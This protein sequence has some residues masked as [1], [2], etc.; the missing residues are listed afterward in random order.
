MLANE[1]R[2]LERHEGEGLFVPSDAMIHF[3]EG[4]TGTTHCEELSLSAPNGVYFYRDTKSRVCPLI[5]RF[6][7]QGGG[8]A[9]PFALRLYHNLTWQNPDFWPGFSVADAQGGPIQRQIDW[10]IYKWIVQNNSLQAIHLEDALT[11]PESLS[12]SLPDWLP[13]NAWSG[14]LPLDSLS[15]SLPCGRSRSAPPHLA[16]STTN[17][18]W[19]FIDEFSQLFDE[20]RSRIDERVVGTEATGVA[21]PFLEDSWYE[22]F[23]RYASELKHLDDVFRELD[24]ALQVTNSPGMT[25]IDQGTLDTYDEE[26]TQLKAELATQSSGFLLA[27]QFL[28]IQHEINHSLKILGEDTIPTTFTDRVQSDALQLAEDITDFRTSY[29]EAFVRFISR[30]E[31]KTI[32]DDFV[33]LLQGRTLD[34][35][36]CVLINNEPVSKQRGFYFYRVNQEV[37]VRIVHGNHYEQFSL[38]QIGYQGNFFNQVTWPS[39]SKSEPIKPPRDL[40]ELLMQHCSLDRLSEQDKLEI[41]LRMYNLI[42]VYRRERVQVVNVTP[43]NITDS[44]LQLSHRVTDV[45]LATFKEINSAAVLVDGCPY[46]FDTATSQYSKWVKFT[47]VDSEEALRNNQ[48]T[49]NQD[50]LIIYL[51]QN[52]KTLHYGISDNQPA[53]RGDR[54]GSISATSQGF[55]QGFPAPNSSGTLENREVMT[56]VGG[57]LR[58]YQE[59]I[60]TTIQ[61]QAGVDFIHWIDVF[62]GY[63]LKTA[64]VNAEEVFRHPRTA[65]SITRSRHSSR[66][67]DLVLQNHRDL[68]TVMMGSYVTT[69]VQTAVGHLTEECGAI[70]RTVQDLRDQN[71]LLQTTVQGLREELQQRHQEQQQEQQRFREELQQQERERQ[72]EQRQRDQ[73]RQQE[74]QRFREELQQRHQ[75]QQQEQQ[76]FRE[77]LQQQKREGQQ[78]LER[79]LLGIQAQIQS[80][81]QTRQTSSAVGFQDQP[82]SYDESLNTSS[83]GSSYSPRTFRPS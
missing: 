11:I 48:T 10:A 64:R 21:R 33:N 80:L 40:T 79:M 38:Q 25:I 53:V 4:I 62:E 68:S 3:L 23:M 57:L 65:D 41:Y 20:A 28:K 39:T 63:N 83:V 35:S 19:H 74:Q 1:L 78:Q 31:T 13:G 47:I 42:K 36:R 14:E 32:M 7:E 82:P 55:F 29:R 27:L 76:R 44:M 50:E 34:Y 46:C 60:L 58:N 73:E 49:L 66:R 81:T 37:I 54:I 61:R 77:E 52:C 56:S 6:N 26:W 72:Q 67:N 43:L 51:E 24:D 12:I 8:F 69:V 17:D 2:S 5:L 71:T 30:E 15:Q 18:R 75:E 45:L 9:L 70:R 59:Q 22:C 16:A